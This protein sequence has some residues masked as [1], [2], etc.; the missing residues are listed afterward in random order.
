MQN[1]GAE[2]PLIGRGALLTL[3]PK[4]KLL[5]QVRE[6]MRPKHYSIRTESTYCDWIMKRIETDV[7]TG[8]VCVV[9]SLTE[10]RL[11]G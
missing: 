7:G 1:E 9:A 10:A 2:A 4:L 11:A 5:D 3:D 6:V 8:A